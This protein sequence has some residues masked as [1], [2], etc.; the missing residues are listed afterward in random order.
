MNTIRVVLTAEDDEN[1]AYLLRQAFD[2]AGG[3]CR[4][5]HVPD[6]EEAVN[7]LNGNKGYADRT[8]NPLPD[9][10]LLDLH[11]PG[12]GGFDVLKWLQQ[13]GT[14]DLLPKIVLSSSQIEADKKKAL[15]LGACAYYVKPTIFSDLVRLI[16]ELESKWLSPS[17]KDLG[18]SIGRTKNGA[19]RLN[20]S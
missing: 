4:S 8:Q 15:S 9:L 12:M 16:S 5:F 10:L 11:M 20:A 13:E 17:T 14:F 2:Q 18:Y 19:G 7:Y 3:S 6:G 1:Y